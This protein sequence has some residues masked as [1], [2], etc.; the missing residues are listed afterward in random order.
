VSDYLAKFVSLCRAEPSVQGVILLG[1]AASTG[2][3]DRLS[4]LDLLVITSQRRRLSSPKWLERI[5]PPPLFSWIYQSPIGGQTVRQAVYEGPLVVDIALVSRLQAFLLGLVVIGLNR[6]PVLRRQLPASQAAQLE[7]WCAITVRGT[8]V[9]LDTHGLAQRMSVSLAPEAP[10]VP[11]ED[12]YLNT[13]HS[14]FGLLL[15]ES[16]QLVRHELWMAVGTVDQQAKQCLLTM[17]EWH[18][19]ARDVELGDTWYGGRRIQEWADPRWLAALPQTWPSYDVD[20]AWDALHATLDMFTNL[21]R[22]TAHS[23]GYQ[24]PLRDEL[25]LRSWMAA[26]RPLSLSDE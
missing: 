3:W 17:M 21:A 1:S 14:L 11:T 5:D 23:L 22:D 6:F 10:K 24:Y 16:K 13:V 8:K 15:W 20:A 4:D 2:G 25:S 18:A 19:I 7:A 9:L 12:V 26:R